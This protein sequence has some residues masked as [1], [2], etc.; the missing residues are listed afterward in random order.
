MY[1]VLVTN[2][3]QVHRC[4]RHA[5]RGY[6]GCTRTD[7][8]TTWPMPLGPASS[9]TCQ[10]MCIQPR[11]CSYRVKDPSMNGTTHSTRGDRAVSPCLS[12]GR[13][14]TA[15]QAEVAWIV[16]RQSTRKGML[17]CDESQQACRR[18]V[19]HN[20]VSHGPCMSVQHQKR[21]K[22]YGATKRCP[23]HDMH[24][25]EYPNGRCC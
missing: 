17:S 16:A 3:M 20:N 12:T 15:M 11:G 23:P 13:P 22:I 7:S 2:G 5:G 19:R 18:K 14:T 8:K 1:A 9:S 21:Q 10:T 4:G 6:R 24:P 25:P